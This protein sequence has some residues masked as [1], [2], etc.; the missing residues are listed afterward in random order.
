MVQ[1]FQR[2]TGA[3]SYHAALRPVLA[4]LLRSMLGSYERYRQRRALAM[5]SDAALRDIGLTRREV[6]HETAK[7]SWWR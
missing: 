1:P 6:E 3:R 5:L 7:L 2:S 4:R